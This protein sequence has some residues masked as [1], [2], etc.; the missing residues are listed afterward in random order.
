MYI[1]H[2]TTPYDPEDTWSYVP[3]KNKQKLRTKNARR[4]GEKEKE[5]AARARREGPIGR[6]TAE[7]REE[8]GAEPKEVKLGEGEKEGGLV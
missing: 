7:M 6:L 1:R 2:Q 5:R 4:A 3:T 8:Q